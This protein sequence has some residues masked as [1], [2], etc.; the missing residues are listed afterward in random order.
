MPFKHEHLALVLQSFANHPL[1][2]RTMARTQRMD[3]ERH[4]AFGVLAHNERGA[5]DPRYA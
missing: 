3:A 1:E 5:Y 4:S 2:H